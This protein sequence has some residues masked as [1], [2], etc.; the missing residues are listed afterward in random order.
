MKI[1][2]SAVAMDGTS[3]FLHRPELSESVSAK[4]TVLDKR[5]TE[6]CDG[7]EPSDLQALMSNTKEVV[8]EDMK[9]MTTTPEPKQK[10]LF[11]PGPLEPASIVSETAPSSKA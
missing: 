9:T 6:I 7:K 5:I 1:P 8:T 4:P 2:Q 3:M 10:I 11:I